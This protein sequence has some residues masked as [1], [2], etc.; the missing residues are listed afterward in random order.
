VNVSSVPL[1]P[2]D[3]A[4]E[5]LRSIGEG[6]DSPTRTEADRYLGA[7]EKEGDG[8]EQLVARVV[9]NAAGQRMKSEYAT[10]AQKVAL[11]AIA[12][13]MSGTPAQVLARVGADILS[14]VP[15][16]GTARQMGYVLL[17]GINEAAIDAREKVLSQAIYD[18]SGQMLTHPSG[19]AVQREGMRILADGAR[20]EDG[21]ALPACG[22]PRFGVAAI[23]S[24]ATPDDAATIG[25]FILFQLDGAQIRATDA[26]LAKTVGEAAGVCQNRADAAEVFKDGLRLIEDADPCG[27]ERKLARFGLAAR[28]HAAFVDGRQMGA[29]VLDEIARQTTDPAIRKEASRIADLSRTMRLGWWDRIRGLEPEGRLAILQRDTLRDIESRTPQLDK[30]AQAEAMKEVE[31]LAGVDKDPARQP[32]I[33]VKDDTIVIGGVRIRKHAPADPAAAAAMPEPG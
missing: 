22:V 17:K 12:G 23:Q 5:A 21:E 8:L 29:V 26:T 18:A 32:T 25:A 33:E 14:A 13:G 6:S 16:P 30:R 20:A 11:R 4:R 15:D 2:R 24:A 7:I 28:S 3:R 31:K 1:T 27:I 19:M 10:A 9:G